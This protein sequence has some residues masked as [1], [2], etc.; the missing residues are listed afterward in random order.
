MSEER[1][2]FGMSDDS[3]DEDVEATLTIAAGVL[4]DFP[5]WGIERAC[6]K[7]ARHEVGLD[8]RYAPNDGQIADVVR[9]VLRP[10]RQALEQASGLLAGSVEAGAAIP[11]P[12]SQR[13]SYEELVQ[14]CRIDGLM[15]GESRHDDGERAKRQQAEQ[16]EVEKRNNDAR[17]AEYVRAGLKPPEPHGGIVVSLPMMLKMGFVIEEVRG[18]KVLVSPRKVVA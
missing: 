9:E 1:N 18:E 7:I 17:V 10:Y 16:P 6:L 8:A 4:R 2:R 14:R 15:I 5:A 3:Q 13:P 12:R 11:P